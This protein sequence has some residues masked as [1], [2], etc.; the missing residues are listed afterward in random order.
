[1][2]ALWFVSGAVPA[3]TIFSGFAGTTFWLIIG[4][5]NL[6]AAVKKSGLLKRLTLL[7]LKY[8]KPTY[9][10]QIIAIILVGTLISPLIPATVAKVAIM[11]GL[12]YDISEELELPKRGI[13]RF[14]MLLAQTLT[15][16]ILLQAAI[17]IGVMSGG[18]PTK[19]ISAPMIS[20]GGSNLL[21]N[22]VMVGL[23][24]SV[25]LENVPGLTD[26][27][28]LRKKNNN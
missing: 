13:G 8:F 5:M 25:G 28:P 1:M 17:N 2:C 11:G 15:L 23:I 24:I 22:M 7:C 19:G 10:G 16:L 12:V 27:W 14:G 18:L 20:Y 4:C 9:G 21:M 6:A 3:G 26:N